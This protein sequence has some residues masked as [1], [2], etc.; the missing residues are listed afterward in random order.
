[1]LVNGPYSTH[2]ALPEFA[3]ARRI[4]LHFPVAA[5]S[6]WTS[7]PLEFMAFAMPA[8]KRP[9]HAYLDE[10]ISKANEHS[11]EDHPQPLYRHLHDGFRIGLVS[12]M[13]PHRR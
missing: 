6:A 4:C 1:M 5:R 2:E 8:A 12:W 10:I 13:W 3:G 11:N 7:A 9:C